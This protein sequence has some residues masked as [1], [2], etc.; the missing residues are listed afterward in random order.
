MSTVV[1]VEIND[2]A[3]NYKFWVIREDIL[4]I[5]HVRKHYFKKTLRE[6]SL[7]T[8]QRKSP[9]EGFFS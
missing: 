8:F 7:A 6:D 1:K 2:V 3:I 5:L 4:N 9:F